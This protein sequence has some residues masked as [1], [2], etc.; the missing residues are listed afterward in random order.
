[1]KPLDH[2]EMLELL[3]KEM[4]KNNI[5]L[6]NSSNSKDSRDR[7]TLNQFEEFSKILT[8]VKNSK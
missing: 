7:S 1:M 3:K 2:K 4:E 5:L 8:I 6:P